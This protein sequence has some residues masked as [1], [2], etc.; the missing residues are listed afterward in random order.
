M[1]VKTKY[2]LY[3][4]NSYFSNNELF[5][6]EGSVEHILPENKNAKETLN[7][8]NL[9]ILEGSI[10]KDCDISDYEVKREKYMESKYTWVKQFANET[11]EWNENSVEE[12]AEKLARLCYEKI[13]DQE[14]V[15]RKKQ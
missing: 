2:T 10:N 8:G 14:I 3:K 12:R 7:I 13:L 4:L 6:D 1:N 9:I 11:E 15:A 5:D